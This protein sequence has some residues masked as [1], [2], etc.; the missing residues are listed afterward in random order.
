MYQCGWSGVT[1]G[2]LLALASQVFDVF[3][4][5]DQ[6]LPHQQ[7]LENTDLIIFLIQAKS[8]R[9]EDLKAVLPNAINKLSK[10]KSSDVLV[11]RI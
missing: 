8:N 1:N 2:K 3:F 4:T 7:N 6:N 11:A 10:G 5:I 9:L